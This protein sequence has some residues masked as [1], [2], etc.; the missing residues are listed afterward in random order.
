[1]RVWRSAAMASACAVV[2][3]VGTGALAGNA[4]NPA[5]ITYHADTED[6][7]FSPDGSY[8][9]REHIEIRANNEAG[10]DWASRRSVDY[11][12]L[13]ADVKIIEA[14]TLKADGAIIP[15]GS[16]AIF[17]RQPKNDAAILSGQREKVILFPQFEVGDTAVYTFQ[18]TVHRVYFPGEI[19]FGYN[20]DPKAQFDDM[21]EIIR[22]PNVLSVRTE[23]H[24]LDFAKHT[25]GAFTVYQWRYS[26]RDT[27]PRDAIAISPL[28]RKPR[29][30]ISTFKSFDDVAAAYAALAAPKIAVSPKI[31]EL[32]GELT[33][34]EPDRLKQAQKL[35]QWV[36]RRIRYVAVELGTGSMIPHDAQSVLANGYGD[37]KDH[38][39]LF[40]ALL[41]AKGIKAETAL[42]NYGN[43]YSLTDV[44]NM[45][46][47]NHA[48][49]YLPEFDLFVDSTAA[50]APF[51]ILPFAE[52][53][54]PVLH[55][56]VEHARKGRTPVLKSGVAS[57]ETV[58]DE[59]LSSDGTLSGTT[60]STATGPNSIW[61]RNKG[62]RIL[63]TG[64]SQAAADEL[65]NVY[66]HGSGTFHLG[67][68][69]A[70]APSYQ[71]G[72]DFHADGWTERLKGKPFTMPRGLAV[73]S[74]PG[75]GPMGFLYPGRLKDSEPMTCFSERQAE[76]ITLH[77]P[78]NSRI[79]EVPK[80]MVVETANL[81]FSAQWSYAAN[82]LQVKRE[83]TSQIDTPYCSGNVREE[84]VAALK[85][86]REHYRSQLRV[87]PLHNEAASR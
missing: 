28:M 56:S 31:A 57:T 6:V 53:G 41:K 36:A 15:V 38:D 10:V 22:V 25:S 76:T 71:I 82:T 85:K 35:Y 12:S 16:A 40:Q 17:E 55:A 13:M 21:E 75:N 73:L 81:H 84:S 47:L 37:C 27:T 62:I 74:V 29:F 83:F 7:E 58:T 54:K 18:K 86:I 39:V 3:C 79:V 42:I 59:T 49:T 68:P 50:V 2:W 23:T 63:R 69:Y 52:Y 4:D 26:A 19:T 11:D 1:M 46:T 67:S 66:D 30:Y 45:I 87:E 33:R 51:G 43:E 48:I 65:A 8:V 44:P 61:L 64:P 14:H 70:I 60:K 34:D 80:N 5:A 24:G 32:A 78:P 72:G 77:I 9:L 20:L